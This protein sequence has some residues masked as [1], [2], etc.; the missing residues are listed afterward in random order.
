LIVI[1]GDKSND[2]I[3]YEEMMEKCDELDEITPRE[4]DDTAVIMYTSGTTGKPKGV[5]LTHGNYAGYFTS[6]FYEPYF[7]SNARALVAL[8]MNHVFGL[9]IMIVLCWKYRGTAILQERFEPLNALRD[10]EKYRVTFCPMVPTM[11]LMILAAPEMSSYDT[12]S[13]RTWLTGS[14]P[15]PVEKIHEVEKRLGGVLVNNYGLTESLEGASQTLSGIRKPGSV[16]QAAPGIK[17][18]IMNKKGQE[19]SAG[20]N[21]EICIKGW[22]VMK[23]YLNKPEATAQTLINGWL[24]TGDVGFLDD[25]GHLFVTDRIKDMV[26]RGGEN[27]YSIEVE[28]AIY[29]HPGI[30]EACVIGLPD[31]IYGEEVYAFVRLRPDCDA[32]EMEIMAEVQKHVAKFKCPK[33]ISLWHE[34]P[35]TRTGKIDKK[36]IREKAM[37]EIS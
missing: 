16:G 18:K 7:G 34:L 20:Q 4:D 12:T 35:K 9:N 36:S 8:P 2:L 17:V 10:I 15:F 6:D 21:G 11:Y 27:I 32:T 3:S 37:K 24:H 22:S 33:K 23:G 30:A 31:K 14:A 19:L 26:I 13:V 29:K 5:M 28:N 25:D 1:N